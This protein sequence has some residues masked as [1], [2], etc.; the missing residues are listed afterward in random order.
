MCFHQRNTRTTCRM[1]H[2]PSQSRQR[3]LPGG[4]THRPVN[5][6]LRLIPESKM[7]SS[8]LLFTLVSLA[9]IAMAADLESLRSDAVFGETGHDES[10]DTGHLFAGG[11]RG[12]KLAAFKLKLR[13]YSFATPD[14]P[15]LLEKFAG[16]RK[17]L[18]GPNH[19][20]Q[21]VC[22]DLRRDW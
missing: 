22:G 16:V 1:Q 15:G 11:A 17:A 9:G 10:G 4:A 8:C 21:F 14:I 3:C 18:T 5:G 2:S 19:P 6:Y 20:R 13:V 12:V 7:K